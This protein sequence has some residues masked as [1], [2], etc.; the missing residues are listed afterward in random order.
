[1]LEETPLSTTLQ[2]VY[3][4]ILYFLLLHV[5]ANKVQQEPKH[6]AA[7]NIEYKSKHLEELLRGF[8]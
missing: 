3:F 5:S 6:V 1:L 2:G 7:K 8:F 4:Y